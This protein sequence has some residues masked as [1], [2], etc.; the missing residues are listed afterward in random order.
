MKFFRK[1]FN[2]FTY[3]SKGLRAALSH[4]FAFVVDMAIGIVVIPL[5]FVLGNSIVEYVLLIG[6]WLLILIIELINSA[7]ETVVDRIGR[8]K[9]LLSGRAKDLGAA[10]ALVAWLYFIL[11]WVLMIL[12]FFGVISD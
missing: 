11:V 12:R 2:A 1:I 4:E 8:E 6:S 10:A 3:S 5:A 7:I 9:N